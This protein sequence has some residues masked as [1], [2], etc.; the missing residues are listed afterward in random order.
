MF[1]PERHIGPD[2]KF[3]S[4]EYLSL[5]GIGK[6]RCVGEIMARAEQ[7]IFFASLIQNFKITPAL[8]SPLSFEPVAGL[9]YYPKEF[10]VQF[11]E[12]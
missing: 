6:R 12:R 7:Y 4:S 11:T 10:K 1:K 9:M 2:N 3:H 5:F 8:G